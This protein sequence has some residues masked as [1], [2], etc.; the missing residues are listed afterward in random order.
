MGDYDAYDDD[1]AARLYA[2]GLLLIKE[3][4]RRL[5]EAFQVPQQDGA[6]V[7]ES[8]LLQREAIA[9]QREGLELIDAAT[10]MRCESLKKRQA[11][12]V[13]S[14]QTNGQ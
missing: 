14:T 13:A 3:G 2:A 7:L 10:A 1:E 8:L 4:D 11:T 12:R 6:C 5:M 9:R